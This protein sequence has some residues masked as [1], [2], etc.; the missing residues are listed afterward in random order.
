MFY[1]V[2]CPNTIL[3]D[4]QLSLEVI[5]VKIAVFTRWNATCGISL[6]AEL[7]VREWVRR[8]Y[9]V[10]VFAP[11]IE[12]ASTDWHHRILEVRDEPWVIRC[13]GETDDPNGGFIDFDKILSYDF[14]VFVV[15]AYARQPISKLRELLEKVKKRGAKTVAI[16]HGFKREH[17]DPFA[18]MDFDAYVVFDHRYID[19]LLKPFLDKIGDR[20]YIIPYPCTP[21]L[22]VKAERP[23][24]AEGKILFFSFGRQPAEEYRDYFEAL[25]RLRESYDLVYWIIRSDGLLNVNE[26][27]VKQW[28][29]RPPLNVL[30]KY[31]KA[32]DIHLLPKGRSKYVVVSSTVYQT[33]GALVP[34]VTPNTR[35]V[36]TIPTDSDG[37]GVIVKYN[38]VEDLVRK[39]RLLIEDPGVRMRVVEEARRF[40]EEN[41]VERIAE[42]YIELFKSLL[43]S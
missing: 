1:L 20:V 3:L 22:E 26:K 37:I 42:K 24:F 29:M 27:W 7:I 39:L 35:Y 13:Y 25:R 19:E 31:L 9:D 17:T 21:P 8:G 30:Y 4:E 16:I 43:S 11:T 18:L 38:D 33:L 2:P 6:H 32:S 10:K 15:E 23:G 28:W 14:D 34:I 41:R 5:A 40:V 36:E 12:S